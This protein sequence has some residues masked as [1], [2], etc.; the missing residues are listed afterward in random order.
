MYLILKIN[1][2]FV[3]IY[4]HKMVSSYVIFSSDL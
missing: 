2:V 4:L 3:H 1:I